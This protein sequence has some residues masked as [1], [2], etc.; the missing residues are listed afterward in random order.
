[1]STVW[2]ALAFIAGNVAGVFVI[3]LCQMAK[4]S[5]ESGDLLAQLE[6]DRTQQ[7]AIRFITKPF[8]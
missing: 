5:R 4:T 1:V 7:Q 2:L 8:L 6:R 3:S